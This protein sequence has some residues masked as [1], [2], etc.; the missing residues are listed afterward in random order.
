MARL[1]LHHVN[2]GAPGI[3]EINP[4]TTGYFFQNVILFSRTVSMF[5][6]ET[7]KTQ[8]IFS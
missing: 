4:N 3:Y 6:Y 7:G 1:T 5:L 8:L 2:T